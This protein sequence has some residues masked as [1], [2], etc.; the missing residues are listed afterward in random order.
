[1]QAHTLTIDGRLRHD[2][3][4]LASLADF[5]VSAGEPIDAEIVRTN[6]R[7]SLYCL[8]DVARKAVF[9][10]RLPGTLVL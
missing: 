7:L 1:M 2:V 3:G 6:P 10:E 8:D 4:A 9:V 5:T